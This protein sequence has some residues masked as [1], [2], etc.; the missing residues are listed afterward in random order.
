MDKS[1]SNEQAASGL[2][3]CPKCVIGMLQT[4][5][6]PSPVNSGLGLRVPTECNNCGAVTDLL[7]TFSSKEEP[8]FERKEQW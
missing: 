7:Y 6:Y 5:S 8:I 2:L 1:S 4:I 3:D